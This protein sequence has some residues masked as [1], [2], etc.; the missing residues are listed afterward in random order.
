[1]PFLWRI[2]FFSIFLFLITSMKQTEQVSP[3]ES[4]DAESISVAAS[5]ATAVKQTISKRFFKLWNLTAW[6]FHCRHGRHYARF[7]VKPAGYLLKTPQ[8]FLLWTSLSVSVC[9]ERSGFNSWNKTEAELSPGFTCIYFSNY[10]MCNSACVCVC[11]C[12]TVTSVT[13]RVPW[14]TQFEQSSGTSWT[15]T[16]RESARRSENL[17]SAEVKLPETVSSVS[18]HSVWSSVWCRETSKCNKDW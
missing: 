10:R 2:T 5:T 11:V 16:L 8:K 18:C 3:G 12:Q 15:K 7:T 13:V 4:A 9:D 17:E 14:R 1:M 6:H